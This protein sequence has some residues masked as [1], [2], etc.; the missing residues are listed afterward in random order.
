MA[1]FKPHEVTCLILGRISVFD[2][3]LLGIDH[4]FLGTFAGF[5]KLLESKC[6][7]R[8]RG[9]PIGPISAQVISHEEMEGRLPR[10]FTMPIVVCEFSDR[11]IVSPV[12]L[13][14]V[15][16]ASQILF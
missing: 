4:Q 2:P 6:H 1:S 7:L 16:V 8:Y 14:L 11:E 5:L 3:S 9:W 15:Y 13:A 12:I 10:G